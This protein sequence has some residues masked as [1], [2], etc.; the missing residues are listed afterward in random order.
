L[1]R[2][3]NVLINRRRFMA[4]DSLLNPELFLLN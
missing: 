4:T 2:L 3:K 1:S